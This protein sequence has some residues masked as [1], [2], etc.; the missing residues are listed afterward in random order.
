MARQRKGC[1]IWRKSGWNALVTV[2][3]DGEVVRNRRAFSTA[4]AMA[5]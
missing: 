3:V 1:L 5:A 4:L 2:T